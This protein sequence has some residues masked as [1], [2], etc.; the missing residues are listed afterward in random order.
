M[1]EGNRLPSLESPDSS[2]LFVLFELFVFKII[3]ACS[4]TGWDFP[5]DTEG[6]IEDSTF[7]AA[8][9]LALCV[10]WALEVQDYAIATH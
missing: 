7:Y 1:A 2:Q 5:I 6:V 3:P 8:Y 9:Q 10:R 4:N